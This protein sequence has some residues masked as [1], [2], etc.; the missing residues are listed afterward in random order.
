M[1]E[2]T[3]RGGNDH[4]NLNLVGMGLNAKHIKSMSPKTPWDFS[5]ITARVVLGLWLMML[6]L[7][8]VLR[9][10]IPEFSRKVADYKILMDPWNLPAAYLVA[11]TEILAGLCL[12][13]GFLSRGASRVALGLTFV[14]MAASAQAWALGLEDC[15]CFGEWLKIGH[16]GKMVLLGVQLALLA[17]VIAT[18]SYASK[19]IFGGRRMRLPG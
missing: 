16:P 9:V 8:K 5:I 6:G 7:D 11:W 10:G 1:A 12:M 4:W 18:E 13:S 17:F 15:G 14:F 19:R 2:F 3:G